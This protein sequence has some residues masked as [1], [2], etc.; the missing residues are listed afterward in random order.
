MQHWGSCQSLLCPPSPCPSLTFHILKVAVLPPASGLTHMV[1]PLPHFAPPGT[2]HPPDLSCNHPSSQRSFL[3][4]PLSGFFV[5]ISTFIITLFCVV[6]CLNRSSSPMTRTVLIQHD[7]PGVRCNGSLGEHLQCAECCP[8][9]WGGCDS[10]PPLGPAPWLALACR[11]HTRWPPRVRAK[12][13]AAS[14]SCRTSACLP[15]GRGVYHLPRSPLQVGANS[16]RVRQGR[17]KVPANR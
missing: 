8:G 16:A 14:L 3:S 5:A 17:V 10:G 1:T 6:I 13:S 2:I 12:S 11:G 9:H 4:P 7:V 15:P